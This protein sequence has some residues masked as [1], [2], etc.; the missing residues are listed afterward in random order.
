MIITGHMNYFNVNK[1]GLYRQGLSTPKGIDLTETFQLITNWVHGKPL[2]NTLPWNAQF[3]QGAS[4]CYCKDIYTSEDNGDV[5]LVLWKSDTAS[6]GTILG[7][8]EDAKTGEGDVIEYTGDHK[9]KKMI[10]GRPMYYWIIPSKQ[11]VVSIKFEHSVCDS[12]LFQDWISAAITNR[13]DH[14]G[15]KKE[16]TETGQTRISFADGTI[17]GDYRYRYMFDVSLKTE[18]TASATMTALASSV[19]HIIKRETVTIVTSDERAQW[20]RFFDNFPLIKPAPNAK[21]R[22]IEIKAE[23]RP[24]A[25]QIKEIIETYAKDNRQP[26]EWDNVGFGTADRQTIWVDR[27]RLKH[28]IAYEV[29]K[30]QVITAVDLHEAINSRRENFLNPRLG[31]GHTVAASKSGIGA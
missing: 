16:L 8:P 10:W 29:P 21:T 22:Q 12:Q 13:V 15:K 11:L 31:T 30:E 2:A 6:N 20:V 17:G 14:T 27:Y 7:A 19:T 24:T 3:R 4:Q 9:G 23:A 5:V 1:C 25:A 28:A 26:G 18:D